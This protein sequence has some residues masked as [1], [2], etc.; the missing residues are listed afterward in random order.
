MQLS[1]NI[2]KCLLF[3]II[4]TFLG[5]ILQSS[6][7]ICTTWQRKRPMEEQPHRACERWK[8]KQKQNQVTSHSNWPRVL[9]FDLV[10]KQCNAIIKAFIKAWLH[11]LTSESKGRFL[12]NKIYQCLAQH[13][14]WSWHKSN[15]L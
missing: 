3:I 5:L 1:R 7:F 9:L 14:V 6:Y 10:Y 2:T 15:F 8:S 11:C 12:V 4:H 13:D